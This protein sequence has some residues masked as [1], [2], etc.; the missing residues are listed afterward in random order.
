MDLQDIAPGPV[1][2]GDNYDVVADLHS[3]DQ[4]VVSAVAAQDFRKGL[5]YV[6]LIR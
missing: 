3:A 6:I 4:T 5:N 1:Q 2:P